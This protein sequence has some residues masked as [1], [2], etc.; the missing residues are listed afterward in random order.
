MASTRRPTILRT[1]A[2]IRPTSSTVRLG[3]FAT[4]KSTTAAWVGRQVKAGDIAGRLIGQHRRAGVNKEIH[5]EGVPLHLAQAGDRR[6]QLVAGQVKAQHVAHA[7][8]Q[9]V[10]DAFF[11]RKPGLLG[12]TPRRR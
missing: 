6:V 4:S 5:L 12:S 11:D 1:S 8:A 3:N 7:N 10:G 9:G 2:R